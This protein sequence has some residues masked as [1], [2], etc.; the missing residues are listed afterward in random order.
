M[1]EK[2]GGGGGWEKETMILTIGKG[3]KMGEMEQRG[4]SLPFRA[5][6]QAILH[7]K[8]VKV[9][10][11]IYRSASAPAVPKLSFR[12]CVVINGGGEEISYSV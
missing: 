11:E 8:S 2:G 7:L 3:E 5:K 4:Q 9:G 10:H 6:R 12:M 1:E